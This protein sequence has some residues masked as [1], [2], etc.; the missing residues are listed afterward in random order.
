MCSAFP[1]NPL[2]RLKWRSFDNSPLTSLTAAF[3]AQNQK[4]ECIASL[5]AANP[6]IAPALAGRTGTGTD[7]LRLP[8]ERGDAVR[9]ERERNGIPLPPGTWSGLAAVAA[10]RGIATPFQYTSPWVLP[11]RLNVMRNSSI[12]TSQSSDAR[13]N[14]TWR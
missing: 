10:A 5:T 14:S 4:I 11:V 13:T 1:N 9:A 7:R 12:H 3:R 6:V 2:C 8:G